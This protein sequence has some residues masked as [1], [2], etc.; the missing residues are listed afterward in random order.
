MTGEEKMI[1]FFADDHYGS[2]PGRNI[3]EHLP[4]ELK[5]RI[6]FQE[7]DWKLLESGKWLS[8]CELLILNLIATTCDLPHPGAG[9]EKAVRE[10]CE[11]GGNALLLHGASAA[12]WQWAWWRGIVGYRW[13]RPGDP[14]GIPSSTHPVEPYSLRKVKVRHPLAAELQEFSMPKDE[15]YT[16]LEQVSPAMVLMDTRIGQGVYP[17]CAEAITPWGGKFLSFLPGHAPEVTSSAPFIANV[18]AMIRYL[19]GE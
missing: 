7:N 11:K 4:E 17:Q 13:V 12:F 1:Y 14:D 6:V 5:R 8:D 18:T 16:E 3:F 9:A 2:F 15:I 19:L 10:W